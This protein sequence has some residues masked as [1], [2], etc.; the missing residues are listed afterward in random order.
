MKT[1]QRTLDV[2][3]EERKVLLMLIQ[4]RQLGINDLSACFSPP[5]DKFYNK[6]IKMVKIYKDIL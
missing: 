5:F 2:T 6:L 3:A 4:E 1:D